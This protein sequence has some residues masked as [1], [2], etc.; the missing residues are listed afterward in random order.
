MGARGATAASEAGDVVI[1]TDHLER[2]AEALG[3]ARRTRAVAFQSASAGMALSVM[4]MV[5]A[6]LG[7]LAPVAGAVAQ[8]AIDVAVILYAL[9]ALGGARTPILAAADLQL[10]SR[11]SAAHV[12]LAGSLQQIRV[13]ADELDGLD[14]R[15]RRM[16]AERILALLVEEI[17]PHEQLDE[18]ALY[19]AVARLIGGEDP[20]GPMSRA[21]VEIR[22][23]VRLLQRFLEDAGTGGVLDEDIIELR[24]LLYSLY[25]VL[26]LHFS[27][28]EQG[29]HS[30]LAS[31]A[32]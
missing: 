4:A 20:T 7:F 8:E 29:Y 13:T 30:L 32:D 19:P 15:D 10:G 6:A 2:L 23:L 3:I 25:V 17:L 5:I 31:R 14:P 12:Q 28:E 16:R 26:T 24:R 18:E 1:L 21:H 9:R 27:Q 22:H 11:L